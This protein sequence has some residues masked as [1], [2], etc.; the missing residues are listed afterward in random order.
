MDFI[1]PLVRVMM[2]RDPSLRPDAAAA[3][4]QW[5][6]I[7]GNMRSLHRC[8]RLRDRSETRRGSVVSDAVFLVKLG[9]SLVR[10]SFR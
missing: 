8:W 10:R 7:L 9:I 4:E 5:R 6:E 2:A 1:R 3:L